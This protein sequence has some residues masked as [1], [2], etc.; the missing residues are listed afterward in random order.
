MT[1]RTYG[2]NAKFVY[3]LAGPVVKLLAAKSHERILDLG[4]GDG[5]LTVQLPGRVVAVDRSK[6]MVEAARKRGADART[7]AGE[8][9]VFEREFDAVFSNAALHWIPNADAV[10]AGVARALKPGG[11]FVGEFGG[12]GNVAAVA[13]AIRAVVG[14]RG[15]PWYFPSPQEYSAVL[16]RHRFRVRS[17]EL[18][19]RPTKLP[20]DME[21][22]LA[23]FGKP[24]RLTKT[25]R[26][27]VVELLRPVLRNAAG[28]W[29]VDYVRLRF[30]ARLA[31]SSQRP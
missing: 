28:D 23:T 10:A 14:D 31:K 21:G 8:K 24:F 27:R 19:P 9:L 2:R 5:A 6:A 3:E 17:I 30:A 16:D 4:C 26:G 11:R 18:I 15:W 13:T 7:M 1:P 29:Y 25:E 12:F 22:W 20:T